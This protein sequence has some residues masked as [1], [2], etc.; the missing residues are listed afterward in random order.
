V[1]NIERESKM[2]GRIH[3]KGVLILTG[4]LARRFGQDKPLS[5]SASLCFEQ[6]YGQIEGDSASCTELYTLLS[7]LADL[8]LRQDIAV[9]GSVNQRGQVQPIGGVNEKI[10]GFFEVCKAKGLTGTQG[11]LIPARN[12]HNLGLD[13]EVVQAVR[14]GQFHIYAVHTVEEG[15]ELLTGV[16]AGERGG[17][18]SYP[19]DSVYGRADRRLREIAGV[20]KEFGAFRHAPEEEEDQEEE[21]GE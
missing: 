21:D 2:S 17:D 11:V 3:N 4:Y 10:E 7:S 20:L 12:L 15:I 1:V 18:G 14:D 13:A 8:P 19:E 6:S 9:T 5:L 16:P